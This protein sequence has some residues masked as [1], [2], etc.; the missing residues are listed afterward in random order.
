MQE[1]WGG[2]DP[3][4]QE[5]IMVL[6]DGDKVDLGGRSL[7]A[8]ET[9]GH[10]FHHHAFLDDATGIVFSGDALGLRLPDVQVLR[11]TTPPPE[12]H[13][14][15]AIGSIERLR[16]VGASAF[17]L[18]HFGPADDEPDVVCDEAVAALREWAEWVRVARK[19][20]RDLDEVAALV[21]QQARD[22]LEQRVA[23]DALERMENAS[24]YW[25]NTWGYMRYFDK[26][27]AA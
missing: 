22:A 26:T 4:S 12:F 16:R 9:P 10:A 2:I 20:T 21:R 17:W 15:K 13:L 18:T 6:D 11:P 5:R 14:E 7:H 25:M 27:E 19:H 3:I 24:S 1:L 23:D 8:I